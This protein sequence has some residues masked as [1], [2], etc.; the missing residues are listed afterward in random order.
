M[1][2]SRDNANMSVH[3]PHD[4]FFRESFTKP[5]I[6]RSFLQ[7]YLPPALLNQLELETLVLE[8]GSYVDE[9]LRVHQTDILYQVKMITG[10]PLRL[11]L[12]FDHKSAPDR[13]VGLQLLRYMVQ[14]WEENKPTRKIEYLTPIL[15]LVVYHGAKK[16]QLETD[17]HS[18][19]GTLPVELSAYI[20]QYAYQL[21]D[22]SHHSDVEI[23][24]EL[25][26]RVCLLTL[27]AIFD[28]RLH[29]L[30]PRLIELTFRLGEQQSGL[31]YVYTILYYLSVAT[32]KVDL[33]TMEQL[34]L[35]QGEQGAQTMATLAQQWTERAYKQGVEEGIEQGIERGVEQVVIQLLRSHDVVTVSEWTGLSIEMVKHVQ[36]RR[37]GDANDR[38]TVD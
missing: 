11:Y 33:D 36:K 28:P 24:G 13:W 12:L 2:K 7:E 6:I 21:H 14:I 1:Q 23:R 3:H 17:L 18:L 16:W 37:G 35:E 34:L 22:F 30:L 4:R 9:E 31:D 15:P 26:A 20:P 10:Q 5:Q 19:F 27:R 25:W 38:R 29:Q 8:D 32:D